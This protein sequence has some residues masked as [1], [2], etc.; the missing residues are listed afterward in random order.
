[1]EIP[2]TTYL[3][4]KR[5]IFGVKKQPR[6]GH[7]LDFYTKKVV[8]FCLVTEAN[9]NEKDSNTTLS[10]VQFEFIRDGVSTNVDTKHIPFLIYFVVWIH[11]VYDSFDGASTASFLRFPLLSK[12]LSNPSISNSFFSILE[13]LFVDSFRSKSLYFISLPS[14]NFISS[15]APFFSTQSKK[16]LCH[17]AP[18]PLHQVTHYDS[19]LLNLVNEPFISH[20]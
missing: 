18:W 10:D 3:L 6:T 2:Q 8:F 5:Q 16:I 1:M 19:T 9:H 7:L 13:I 20:S 17:I 15:T 11:F 12:L 14:R 4:S